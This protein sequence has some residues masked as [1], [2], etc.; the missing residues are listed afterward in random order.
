[1]VLFTGRIE[2]GMKR[3]FTAV[4]ILSFLININQTGFNVARFSFGTNFVLTATSEVDELI[5][6]ISDEI[7]EHIFNFLDLIIGEQ[8]EISKQE[9]GFRQLRVGLNHQYLSADV[10]SLGV[11]MTVV[12]QEKERVLQKSVNVNNKRKQ[13]IE[14][15]YLVP[16]SKRSSVIRELFGQWIRYSNDTSIFE[17]NFDDYAQWSHWKDQWCNYYL[18]HDNIYIPFSDPVFFPLGHTLMFA[19]T[20][21]G[22]D[23]I[24]KNMNVVASK[25]VV[26]P[27]SPIKPLNP[28]VKILPSGRYIDPSKKLVAL[29]FD[30]GPHVNID[31]ILKVLKKYDSAATFFL[32]G[33]HIN[34]YPSVIAR[35]EASASEIGNHAYSHTNLRYL[36]QSAIRDEIERTDALIIKYGGSKPMVFRPP[37]GSYNQ[38]VLLAAYDKRVVNWNIDPAD[39]SHRTWSKTFGNIK[40]N[41]KDGSI[42]V[43]HDRVESTALNIEILVKYLIDQGYQ[44]VTVS[45]LIVARN[46]TSQY[47]RHAP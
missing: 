26:V 24:I 9:T 32:L 19:Q 6:D 20:A 27:S 41:L 31:H 17:N 29:T 14:L 37:Y 16:D 42:I 15:E 11:V 34:R 38:N 10:S 30:D 28:G 25:P 12:Y 3:F 40:A 22:S 44:L 36:S 1:M 2:K 18:D 35:I 33:T 45:E 7:E 8:L 4:F 21:L 46:V 47:V 13:P 39:W 5:M 43:M 23:K